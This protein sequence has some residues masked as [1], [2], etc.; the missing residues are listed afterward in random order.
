MANSPQQEMIWQ[1]RLHLGD[2]PGIHGDASYS[3]LCAELPITV[4]RFDP[5]AQQFQLVLTT[6]GLET[7]QGYP[8]HELTV[9]MYLPDPNQPFRSI[10]Q[11]VASARFV[12]VDQ[13]T[14]QVTVNVGSEPGPF[15]LSVRLRVDTTVNPGLYDDFIWRRLALKAT[16]FQFFASFGFPS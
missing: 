16:N 6:A 7:F 2:E 9:F 13:N 12:S 14:K 1:G 4:T 3:G 5:V 15:R 11:V 8:G 10:E